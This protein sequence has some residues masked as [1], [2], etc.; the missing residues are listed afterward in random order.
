MANYDIW[1]T[2]RMQ[3][4]G[5]HSAREDEKSDDGN[6]TG[7][8][9]GVGLYSGTTLGVTAFEY[10]KILGH[11]ATLKEMEDMPQDVAHKLFKEGYDC[12]GGEHIG[13]YWDELRGDEIINQDLAGEMC[14]A[15]VNMGETTGIDI[16]QQENGWPVTGKMDDYTLNKINLK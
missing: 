13:G 14:D 6:W 16:M 5:P 12:P 11:P 8:Q 4:E 3:I 10:S 9:Q 15:C 2:N 7:G 1:F